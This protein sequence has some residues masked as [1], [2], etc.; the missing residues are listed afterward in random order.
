MTAR[1]VRLQ[2]DQHAGTLVDN[3]L[4]FGRVL[5]AAGV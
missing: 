5:R 2:P 1:G 4:R 3:V